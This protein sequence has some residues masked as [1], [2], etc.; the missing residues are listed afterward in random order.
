VHAEPCQSTRGAVRTLAPRVD[1][2]PLEVA[3]RVLPLCFVVAC[4]GE[5]TAPTTMSVPGREVTAAA[6]DNV[7]ASL[8]VIPDSQVVFAGDQFRVTARPRNRAGEVVDVGV[9]WKVSNTS[10]VSTV[11]SPQPAMTFKALRVGTTSVKATVGERSRFS[12]VVVRAVSDAKVVVTPAEAT[13]TAGATVQFVATGLTKAGET[14]SVSV[15]WS[16]TA[17]AIS[18]TGVLTA[19]DTPGTYQV[20]AISAFGAADTSV[21]TIDGAPPDPVPVTDV[22]LVPEN[23]A[24]MAGETVEFAAYGRTDGGD[25]VAVSVAYTATGG[26]I[27]ADGKYTAAGAAGTYQVIAASAAGIADTSEVVISA[28]PIARVVLLPDIAAS[29]PGETSRF[30]ASVLNTL[31]QGVPEPVTYEATCGAVTSAGV[32]TAPLG[33]S[34][35]CLVTASSGEKADTTEVV[36]LT[37]TLGQ[38]IPFGLHDLWTTGTRTQSSGIAAYSASHDLP[39][40]GELVSHIAA[41]R[42]RGIRLVLVM[43]GGAHNRYKTDGVFDQAKWEAAMNAFDTPAIRDAVAAGVADGTI[44]GNSVMDEPQQSGTDAKDW[45]PPGTMTKARVDGMCGYVKA[46]F[47]TLPV[48]VGHDHNVFETAN[49]YQVCEFIIVQYAARKGSVAAWRDG[50]LSLAARDGLGVIFS[51]NLLD[52]GTQDRTGVWDCAGTGGLGTHGVNCQMTPAQARDWG[53][54]LGQASC[55]LLSWRY[56]GTFMAKPENQAAISDVAITLSPVPQAPC[57]V[58]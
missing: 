13:V 34:G 8:A 42:A 25:S 43:T 24:V 7:V 50:A 9:V 29:R 20:I 35:P 46:I 10:V 27:A 47:P 52:G 48:G 21:V 36:L 30:A 15:T 39:V 2:G 22:I 56:D 14:A 33:E 38:G 6:T 3:A 45:G 5:S 31:G 41:A 12:K 23:A 19:G 40:P 44:I 53:K 55:A 26:T 28:A 18:P 57:K 58:R 11:G 54:L 49:S 37:N 17:G 51:L 1:L 4:Q 16:G 32:F